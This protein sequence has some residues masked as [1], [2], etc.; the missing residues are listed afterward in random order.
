M[1]GTPFTS[2]LHGQSITF[3]CP[4]GRPSAIV[5]CAVYEADADDTATAEAERRVLAF[6]AEQPTVAL[7]SGP[8]S[9]E[10]MAAI[11]RGQIDPKLLRLNEP[12]STT[13]GSA[14]ERE[15]EDVLR[16][17]SWREV[18]K[19]FEREVPRLSENRM[20]RISVDSHSPWVSG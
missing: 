3:D 10:V 2:A 18:S 6:C 14:S 11:G 20:V 17:L 12:E 5:S 1:S 4:D 8:P 16:R 15:F 13:L 9:P 19:L 7:V